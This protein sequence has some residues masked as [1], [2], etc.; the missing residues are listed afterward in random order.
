ME[1]YIYSSDI[2]L[3]IHFLIPREFFIFIILSNSYNGHIYYALIDWERIC[4]A[5]TDTFHRV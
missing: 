5:A 1:S 2:I 4:I 3:E